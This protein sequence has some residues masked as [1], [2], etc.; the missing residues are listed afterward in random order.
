MIKSWKKCVLVAFITCGTSQT[1]SVSSNTK[2]QMKPVAFSPL[3]QYMTLIHNV[4]PK[5]FIAVY[6]A[7]SVAMTAS[8]LIPIFAISQTV[9]AIVGP[10]SLL[11]SGGASAGVMVYGITLASLGVAAAPTAY[12]AQSD[13]IALGSVIATL[14]GLA[15]AKRGYNNLNEAV[16]LSAED[17]NSSA[18]EKRNSP[19]SDATNSIEAAA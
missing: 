3:E 19:N 11:L 15:L 4:Y 7:V 5:S 16:K 2:F 17:S 8:A 1:Y 10:R 18:T 9:G 14:I 6:T 13:K 12:I